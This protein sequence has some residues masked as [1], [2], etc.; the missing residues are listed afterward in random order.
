MSPENGQFYALEFSHSDQ[1]CF[2][3]VDTETI[4]CSQR[5]NVHTIS[6]SGDQKRRSISGSESGLG[7]LSP[8][9]P[10]P[11]VAR[12]QSYRTPLVGD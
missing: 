6:S 5:A 11:Q 10:A 9:L 3:A 2:Q 7:R 4:T 8:D 1:V 12:S